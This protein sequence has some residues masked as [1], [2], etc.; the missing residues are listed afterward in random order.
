MAGKRKKALSSREFMKILKRNGWRL[1][2]VKRDHYIFKNP[3][4]QDII[5]VTKNH[6]NK[7]ICQ[8]LINTYNLL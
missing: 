3:E 8:R 7:M 5:T 2:R 4:Y 1:T 6:F